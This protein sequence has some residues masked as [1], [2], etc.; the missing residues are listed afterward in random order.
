MGERAE[1]VLSTFSLTEAESKD[2]KVVVQKFDGHFVKKRNTIFERA[3]FNQRVQLAGESVDAFITDLHSLAE[4]CN[5]G[6]PSISNENSVDKIGKK[7]WKHRDIKKPFKT[8]ESKESKTKCGRC[9][10]TPAHARAQCPAADAE[11]HKCKKKGHFKAMCRSEKSVREVSDNSEPSL[12]TIDVEELTTD[13]WNVDVTLEGIPVSF[14][15]DTG[16]DVT[17]IPEQIFKK[18][19]CKRSNTRLTGPGQQKL[20]VQGMIE[21]HI[22]HKYKSIKENIFV[23]KDLMR[24]LLGRPTIETLN[25]VSVINSVKLTQEEICKKF[26]KLFKGLGKLDTEYHIELKDGAEPYAVHTA[27]RVA[28]PLLP[29]VKQELSGLRRRV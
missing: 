19:G 23:V 17:V 22:T 2:Y 24:P 9:G 18:T 10:K 28:L 15:L 16:A 12:G 8:P 26:S 11:C 4:Y 25:L 7:I 29:K 5:Y 27:R 20:K 1:D 6:S 21:A 14:K 3:K 13:C